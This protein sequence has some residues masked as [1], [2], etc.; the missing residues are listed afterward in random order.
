MNAH[1]IKMLSDQYA[2]VKTSRNV[3][4]SYCATITPTHFYAISN[5]FGR[6]S[7]HNL[8]A[9]ISNTY[10]FWIG[11]QFLGKTTEYISY[12]DT[13]PFETFICVFQDIDLLMLSFFDYLE[14]HP[15]ES[16]AYEI[17]DKKGQSS[18][19]EVFTHVITHEYHHK[20]QLLSLSRQ[21]GYTPVDTDVLR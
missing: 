18:P 13:T 10:N 14:S 7:I 4:L 12:T 19:L 9:H 17:E 2:L 21:L 1:Q 8:L 11:D 16:F 5:S 15:V 20:G 3:L 6:G